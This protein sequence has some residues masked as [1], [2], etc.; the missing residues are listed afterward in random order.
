MK[1]QKEKARQSN[2]FKLDNQKIDWTILK[3]T[4]KIQIS[5]VMN[6]QIL[7]QIL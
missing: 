7:T 4:N 6:H 5:L 3:N 2:K 1:K